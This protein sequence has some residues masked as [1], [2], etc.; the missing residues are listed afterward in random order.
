MSESREPPSVTLTAIGVVRSP[1]LEK[2]QAPR[3]PGV[4][5]AAAGR[6]ELYAG[7]GFEH[8]LADLVSFRHVWLLFW[9]DRAQGFRPKVLPPR[10]DK[11]RGVFATRSP[12]R[13]NPLG[14]SLVE[15]VAIEGLTLLV[16]GL[17]LLDG[18]PVLDIKPYL[19]YADSRPDAGHGWIDTLSAPGQA[20][21][22]LPGYAVRLEALAERQLA[23]LRERFGVELWPAIRQALEL[24]PEPHPYRRI[25]R[26]ADGGFC[27][28]IKDF[29]VLFRVAEREIV[30]L[31]LDTGYKPSQ[32]FG[33][34][35]QDAA[36]AA[37]RA[38]FEQRGSE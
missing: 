3:Q 17:D 30:V 31:S 19:P 32:L 2:R 18:T 13:P 5:E 25:R 20:R 21:D 10:S 24:G 22:P 33:E 27:L 15:L 14:L 4:V 16:N 28:A 6:V 1:F 38:L 37:H 29:R 12:H 26:Q 8:A 9:F 23:L 7:R 34:T 36:L 35:A 11:R